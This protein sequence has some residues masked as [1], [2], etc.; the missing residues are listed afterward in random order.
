MKTGGPREVVALDVWLRTGTAYRDD[1]KF[2]KYVKACR[3]KLENRLKDNPVPK[4]M[5]N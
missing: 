4:N 5:K 1:P 3:D 2:L